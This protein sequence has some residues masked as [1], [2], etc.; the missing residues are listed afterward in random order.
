[1]RASAG[2]RRTGKVAR[3]R[4]L[5]PEREYE[6]RRT[7]HRVLRNIPA[8]AHIVECVHLASST[9]FEE[10][11]A[12]ARAAFEACRT[13]PISRALRHVFFA[14]RAASRADKSR[15]SSAVIIVSDESARLLGDCSSSSDVGAVSAVADP[16]FEPAPHANTSCH[17]SA[18]V[19]Y[20]PFKSNSSAPG[21]VVI[22][23]DPQTSATAVSACVAV[24]R[25]AGR[26]S[27][28][29]AGPF[30]PINR[31][32]AQAI[33]AST[34]QLRSRGVSEDAVHRALQKL[35]LE[36]EAG[37]GEQDHSA[38]STGG[39][40]EVL[41][42]IVGALSDIGKQLVREGLLTSVDD[43]DVLMIYGFGFSRH[44][45]GPVWLFDNT[46]GSERREMLR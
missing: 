12:L 39:D 23:S 31:R 21:V 35:G 37:F 8:A 16:E 9:P 18:C 4:S 15:T 42:T 33:E 19:G 17:R 30:A 36:P 13:G 3:G 40:S 14:E 41:D 45:G 29:V 44:Y 32:I 28:R 5:T 11:V 1:V 27:I 38:G 34:R 2:L 25:K 26:Q 10:G 6:V 43:F 22:I 46:H 24:A 20:L 7:Y